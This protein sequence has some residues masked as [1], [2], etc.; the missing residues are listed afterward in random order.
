MLKSLREMGIIEC[1]HH[2]ARVSSNLAGVGDGD[3]SR[4]GARPDRV[5]YDDTSKHCVL[6]WAEIINGEW[7][8]GS[9]DTVMDTD[10]INIELLKVRFDATI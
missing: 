7:V 3:M 4:G 6:C 9:V 8:G 2:Q 5:R 1:D 10:K